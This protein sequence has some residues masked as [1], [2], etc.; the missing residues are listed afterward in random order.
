MAEIELSPSLAHR[1]VRMDWRD[2]AK[3]SIGF[4]REIIS[5]YERGNI[6]ALSGAPFHVDFGL[7]ETVSLPRGRKFQKLSDRFL[8]R[9]KLYRA[10][11]RRLFRDVFGS[12]FRRYLAFRQEVSRLSTQLR[13]FACSVFRPYRFLKLSVSW[14]FTPT[15]PEGLHV[16]YFRRDGDLH[17]LRIFLNVDREPRIWTV[18]YALEDLIERYYDAA[19]LFEL[20][21]VPSNAICRRLNEAVFDHVNA[22]PR[23]AM[24]RHIVRFAPGDVWLCE[25]RLNSHEIYSGHR[26]VATDF[27]V[28]PNSMLDPSQRVEARAARCMQRCRSSRSSAH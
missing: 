9:P 21:D 4:R 18:S 7:L 16:D 6:V 27:Y 3:D 20:A 19:R 22:L 28:D 24:D 14:R 13:E 10:D 5:N 25:T 12:D 23:G 26:L 11:V 15:G 1:F 2:D 8:C 17:Y